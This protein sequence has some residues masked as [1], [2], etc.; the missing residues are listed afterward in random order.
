[1]PVFVEIYSSS[2]T[3]LPG[4]T[5]MMVDAS[6]WIRSPVNVLILIVST[7]ALYFILII[8]SPCQE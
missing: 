1:M 7:I 2:G 8:F 3:E 4:I 6:N 5:Q